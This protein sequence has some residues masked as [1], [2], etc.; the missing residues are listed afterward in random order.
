MA[1]LRNAV[2]G[3]ALGP[4]A[5]DGPFYM[6]LRKQRDAAGR[7][8]WEEQGDQEV[9][10]QLA[11]TFTQI[12][13]LSQVQALGAVVPALAAAAASVV[14]ELG[15]ANRAGALVR[16]AYIP[17]AAVNGQATNSRTLNVLN[18]GASGAGAV[19]MTSLPL[20]AGTNLLAGVENSLGTSGALAVN[21]GDAIQFQSALVGT[22][23]AD[24]GGIIVVTLALAA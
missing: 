4:I 23:L 7:P 15:N 5:A 6:W 14:Y 21:P 9:E 1:W 17:N 2:T 12:A 19:N 3:T 18:G 22:G 8:T 13:D 10:A 20:V 24:P 11:A 16:A